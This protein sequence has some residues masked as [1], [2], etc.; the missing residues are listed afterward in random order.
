MSATASVV[1][2]FEVCRLCS[3]T[4]I[5]HAC[6]CM[7]MTSFP[8]QREPDQPGLFPLASP[9]D[10][11]SVMSQQIDIWAPPVSRSEFVHSGCRPNLASSQIWVLPIKAMMLRPHLLC[12]KASLQIVAWSSPCISF[13]QASPSPWFMCRLES[14]LEWLSSGCPSAW[15][16][17]LCFSCM[18]LGGQMH[19]FFPPQ[20]EIYRIDTWPEP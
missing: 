10:G 11:I 13:T 5:A 9:R 18:S 1:L 19:D 16:R 2:Y 8:S 12:L 3:E 14:P 15:Y 7:L 20:T 6:G 4:S 17:S